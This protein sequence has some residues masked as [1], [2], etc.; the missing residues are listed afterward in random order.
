MF[1]NGQTINYDKYYATLE[2]TPAP[3]LA[4]QLPKVHIDLAG[5]MKYAHDKGK[6]AGE[7]TD[8]EKNYFIS[9]DDVKSLQEKVSTSIKYKSLAEWNASIET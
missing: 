4:S 6:K 9:D 5:L 7:L 2:N 8:E 1:T 3:I